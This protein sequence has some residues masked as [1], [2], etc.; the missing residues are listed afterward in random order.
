MPKKMRK[1]LTLS[2]VLLGIAI[3][4]GTIWM[5]FR[6]TP[7]SKLESKLQNLDGKEILAVGG[8]A[9][10]KEKNIAF[11]GFTYDVVKTPSTVMPFQADIAAIAHYSVTELD[12]PPSKIAFACRAGYKGGNWVITEM[13]EVNIVE[14]QNATALEEAASAYKMAEHRAN[15]IQGAIERASAMGATETAETFARE[16]REMLQTATNDLNIATGIK[17][18]N[19]SSVS[20]VIKNSLNAELD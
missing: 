20:D 18:L 6:P 9:P 4:G 5:F 13:N 16:F 2:A 8:N 15:K 14:G 1:L 17:E 3:L 10:D 11:S 7:T 19:E 12:N